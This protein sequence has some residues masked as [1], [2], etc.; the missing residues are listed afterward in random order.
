[1]AS[2]EIAQYYSAMT[3]DM[4]QKLSGYAVSLQTRYGDPRIYAQQ[5]A[6]MER[7]KAAVMHARSKKTESLLQDAYDRQAARNRELHTERISTRLGQ[8]SAKRPV[9]Q[10]QRARKQPPPA[11]ERTS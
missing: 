10:T 9:S 4:G 1:M 11:D 5:Q 8:D 7:D 3:R 2:H 6:E